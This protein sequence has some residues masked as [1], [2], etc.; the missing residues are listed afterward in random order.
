MQKLSVQEAAQKLGISK[1]AIYNRIRRNT[2]ESVEEDGV[3][4]VILDSNVKKITP[5]NTTRKTTNKSSNS[6]FIK[7]LTNEIEYLKLKNKS[8]EE[9]KENLFREKEELLISSKNEIK[10]MY[11]ERDEKLQYFLSLLE[12]PTMTKKDQIEAKAIDI[13]EDGNNWL[14]LKEYLNLFEFKKKKRKKVKK[15]IVESAYDNPDIKIIGGMLFIHKDLDINSFT[16]KDEI[17]KN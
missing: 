1:E 16:K 12:K 3:K 11:K 7:Y 15:I 4:Y 9:D 2:I 13:K 6:E 10:N 14:K 8:L 5:A 17:E